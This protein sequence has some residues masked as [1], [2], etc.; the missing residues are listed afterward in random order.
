[1]I[2]NQYVTGVTLDKTGRC[3][4]LESHGFL[5]NNYAGKVLEKRGKFRMLDPY[6]YHEVSG[7]ETWWTRVQALNESGEKYDISKVEV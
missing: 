2:A 1:M 5:L 6:H 4:Q 7:D 3:N